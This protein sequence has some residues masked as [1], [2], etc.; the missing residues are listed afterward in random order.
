MQCFLVNVTD[1]E[2]NRALAL[3]IPG[4]KVIEARNYGMSLWGQTARI[5][6]ELPDGKKKFYFLK[7][8]ALLATA[9]LAI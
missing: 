8:R 7:V 6:T 2:W 5:E 3:P 1:S 9:M 4:T